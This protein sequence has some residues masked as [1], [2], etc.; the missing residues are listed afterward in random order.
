MKTFHKITRK[1]TLVAG[2][3]MGALIISTSLVQAASEKK[4]KTDKT[5][6]ATVAE[7]EIEILEYLQE[8]EDLIAEFKALNLP[9]IK[10]FDA[11]DELVFQATVDDINTIKD[12]KLRSLLYQSDFLMSFENTS[13]YRLHD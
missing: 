1:I 5:Y 12:K 4:P 13:Y 11:N 2:I 6:E 8:E 9:T 3:V 7:L 10:I